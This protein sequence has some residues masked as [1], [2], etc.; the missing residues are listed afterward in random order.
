MAMVSSWMIIE[1]LM[2]GWMLSANIVAIEKEP[3]DMVFHSPRIV[4]LTD[5]K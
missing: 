1:A 5:V 2:Y 4:L 3:P